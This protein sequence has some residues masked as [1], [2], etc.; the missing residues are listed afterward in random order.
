MFIQLGSSTHSLSVSRFGSCTQLR[1]CVSSI[2]SGRSSKRAVCLGLC[3]HQPHTSAQSVLAQGTENCHS[4]SCKCTQQQFVLEDHRRAIYQGH[5][6]YTYQ[7]TNTNME[8]QVFLAGVPHPGVIV[9]MRYTCF[10]QG[11]HWCFH[12]AIEDFCC[13]LKGWKIDS[14]SY[15]LI[16]SFL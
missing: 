13:Y 2:E 1:S 11:I 9:P 4:G 15:L 5:D 7:Y 3:A 12:V 10:T 6:V 14:L 16:A 8:S